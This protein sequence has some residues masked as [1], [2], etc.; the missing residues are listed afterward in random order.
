MKIVYVSNFSRI[1]VENGSKNYFFRDAIGRVVTCKRQV[2][3]KFGSSKAA[4]HIDVSNS[5]ELVT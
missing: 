5:T 3:V 1:N 4:V 2:S